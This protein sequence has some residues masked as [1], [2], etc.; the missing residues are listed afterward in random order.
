VRS[1]QWITPASDL[2]EDGGLGASPSSGFPSGNPSP[3]QPPRGPEA[4]LSDWLAA[5]EAQ[6]GSWASRSALG[7]AGRGSER[8]SDLDAKIEAITLADLPEHDSADEPPGQPHR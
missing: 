8:F 4:F 2:Q 7:H 5:A 3:P 1:Q 6:S